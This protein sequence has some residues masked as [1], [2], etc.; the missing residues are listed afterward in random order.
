MNVFLAV[1]NWP[2]LRWHGRWHGPHDVHSA[3]THSPGHGVVQSSVS[4]P[5]TN[6]SMR[7]RYAALTCACQVYKCRIQ[8]SIPELCNSSINQLQ[9]SL[10]ICNNNESFI[11]HAKRVQQGFSFVKSFRI[12]TVSQKRLKLV[13][14]S[15]THNDF[16][17]TTV[18]T[19][20]IWLDIQ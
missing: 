8:T 4:C 10:I 16:K 2:T 12:D 17:T 3:T 5:R 15:G 18:W 11:S 6:T 9:K 14:I 20:W 1:R 13:I 7:L 19:L